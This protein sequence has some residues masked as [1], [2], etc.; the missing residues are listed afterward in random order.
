VHRVPLALEYDPLRVGKAALA[1]LPI[2]P[3]IPMHKDRRRLIRVRVMPEFDHLAD[4]AWRFLSLDAGS[5]RMLLDDPLN[6]VSA[7]DQREKLSVEKLLK[8]AFS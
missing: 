2:G 6:H 8:L 3:Q 5:R 7:Q 4:R 1:E